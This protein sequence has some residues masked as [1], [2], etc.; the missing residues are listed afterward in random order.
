MP[1]GLLL[2]L[3]P[4]LW[5][6]TQKRSGFL[7]FLKWF[8]FWAKGSGV[9]VRTWC[10]FR[11]GVDGGRLAGLGWLSLGSGHRCLSLGSSHWLQTGVTTHIPGPQWE[12]LVGGSESQDSLL[13]Q[14]AS[15]VL[16]ARQGCSEDSVKYC[17]GSLSSFTAA[18]RW[19]LHLWVIVC[20]LS[21]TSPRASST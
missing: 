19:S 3:E 10:I 6:Q 21:E 4:R 20:V 16:P 1:A 14:V 8:S 2:D 9:R 11:D 15:R 7:V 18:S 13:A 12:V 5:T 17:T